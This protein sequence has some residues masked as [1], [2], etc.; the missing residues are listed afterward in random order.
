MKLEKKS[1]QI[2]EQNTLLEE[3]QNEIRLIKK[4]NG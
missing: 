3:L 4:K 1:L 2:A